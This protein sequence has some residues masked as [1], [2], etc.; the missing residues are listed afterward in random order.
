V[1]RFERLALDGVTVMRAIHPLSRCLNKQLNNRPNNRP[2]WQ[3][4]W[5]IAQLTIA[6]LLFA[7]LAPAQN[8]SIQLVQGTFRVTGWSAS[9]APPANG[10][11]SIFAVYAGGSDGPALLGSY[12][13]EN[14]T[15]VF[16]P[17]FPLTRGVRV[18]AVFRPPQGREIEAGFE[19]G[20]AP[21]IA[22]TRVEHV[23]PS[24]DVLPA[25]E[26]KFYVVFSASMARGEAWHH[27]H[28]LESNGSE[29]HSPFLEI[30]QELW[31]RDNTR[32]TVLFDPGRIKRGVL[33]NLQLGMALQEGKRYTLV[34][35]RDWAD[36]HGAH[37]VQAY[38]KIFRAGA[39]DRA[40]ID[41]EKWRLMAPKAGTTDAL[42]V[43]FQKPLDFA[44][45]QRML[46]I[47]GSSGSVPGTISVGRDET[48]WRFVPSA[49]WESGSYQ[50][51]INT[52]L[53]DLAGNKVGEAF[54]VDTFQPVT[55]HI[56]TATVSRPF[57]IR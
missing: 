23:Y 44:L 43:D 39:A 21:A 11:S 45:L 17:Q 47:E 16:R 48:E 55:K 51:G 33:P 4:T 8:I 26:L 13:V 42:A 22:S 50:L 41:P 57:Q 52:E 2:I 53:E 24:A 12:A 29:V 56:A 54:D 5:R 49:P 19:V 25:N 18:R 1:R 7:T 10:W 30:N 34:I 3:L 35:D 14:G 37:L 15:L 9:G 32:L 28:L 6:I 40:P 31:N 20:G 46:T 36:A 38:R 27:I